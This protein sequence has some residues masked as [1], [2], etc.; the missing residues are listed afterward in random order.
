[1]IPETAPPSRDIALPTLPAVTVNARHAAILSSDGELQ[2]L[3]LD[4]AKMILHKQAAYVC[5]APYTKNKMGLEHL[6][7]FDVLELFAFTH[8]ARFCVP[9]PT[10]LCKALSLSPPENFDDAP[11]ALLEIA[12]AL[13]TDLQQDRLAEKADPLKIAAIM[14]LKGKGW[15]W[16]PYIFEALGQSWDPQEE[17]FS[18]SALNIWR[19]LPEWAED[20]PEAPTTL[21][22]IT[23]QETQERLSEM[24]SRGD[25]PREPRPQQK[26]YAAEI[27]SIF[28]PPEN[29]APPHL[30]LAEAGTGIGKTLGYLAP[31]SVWAEKN[32]APVWISTYTKNLQR[33]IDQELDRLYPHPA[34]KDAYV[35]VRK[36]RENYLCLLNLEEAALRTATALN[37]QQ[38]IAAGIMARWSA[39]TKD[40]DL[41]GPDFPGWLSAILG[42]AGTYGLA[43]RRG[44]CIFSACDHYNRC[45][46]ER[47]IRK[48]R[49]ARLVIANHALVMISAALATPGETLPARYV[50]DEGHHLFDAA[51]S[52]FSAHLTAK[53]TA[54]LRR[55]ILGAEGGRQSRARGLKRRLEDLVAGDQSAQSALED[56]LHT[57]RN[58]T[59]H[60]WAKRLQDRQPQG[61]SEKFFETVYHQVYA[62]AP[63][64]EGP[65]A[66]ETPLHPA[67]PELLEQAQNLKKALTAIQK[68]VTTLTKI[69]RAKLE[70]DDGEI[71]AETR[72]RLISLSQSLERR[73]AITLSAWIALLDT[74]TS[75]AHQTNPDFIDWLEIDRTDGRATDIGACR[76]YIDPMK[77]FAGSITPHL[78]GMA[79]TSA[80]LR[81]GEETPEN[82]WESAHIR[83]GSIYISKDATE[84]AFPSPFDYAAQTRI[85]VASDIDKNDIGQVSGAVRALFKSSGGGALGLFT[86][87]RRLRAVHEK[88]AGPLEESGLPLYAQHID[89]IDTG[90]LVDIFRDDRHA[91][92]LGTDAIRDGV[93]VPGDSLR[94][95]VFDRVP[96]PRPTIL[97]KARRDAFGG[98]AYDEA[99]TRLKLRQAFGRLIRREGDKGIFVMLDP[100]LPSRLHSAFPEG[101]EIHKAPLAEIVQNIKNFF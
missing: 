30:L 100:G 36:G 69:L 24:L 59:A 38:A 70:N 83:T 4:R 65:Y 40:G 39:A 7:T 44:E 96:W 58:L 29:N 68:P 52:A 22:G 13:L 97:H 20:A 72:K 77:P 80:T 82:T 87:I 41:S 88:I 3:S 35:A 19:R 18:K 62:R 15:A 25:H 85:F 49:R 26:A 46:V 23:E 74:L 27:A 73:A 78:H 6:D 79:I 5:H 101:A 94:L 42:Y 47:S 11:F 66:L 54:D 2:T 14:G 34:V 43:D 21:F 81:S 64:R 89:D 56:I 31:S 60:G 48:A 55:W 76:H 63:G 17:T 93:D 61:P 51:D 16:T 99:L 1:M 53:E 92:L 10:G 57:A 33:Q 67:S 32:D 71:D 95:I 98:R 75:E 28:A 86:S 37:P 90:T 9:T 50:F 8:P 91:C 12:R 84:S 45:F